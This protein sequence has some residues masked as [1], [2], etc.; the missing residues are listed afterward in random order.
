MNIHRFPLDVVLEYIYILKICLYR[1]LS[2]LGNVTFNTDFSSLGLGS[3]TMDGSSSIVKAS[4]HLWSEE[5]NC[6]TLC[7]YIEW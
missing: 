4:V 6:N 2:Y 5:V 1:I 3:N 7:T